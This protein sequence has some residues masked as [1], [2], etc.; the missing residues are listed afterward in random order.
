MKKPAKRKKHRTT[1]DKIL[2]ATGI[3]FET[4]EKTIETTGKP[5]GFVYIITK[6]KATT[7][8]KIKSESDIVSRH[9]FKGIQFNVQFM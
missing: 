8:E 4:T 1:T 5:L 7:L 3:R 6:A 9:C 2:A